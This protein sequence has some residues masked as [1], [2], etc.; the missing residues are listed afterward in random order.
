MRKSLL[1]SVP[2]SA[3]E[4]MFSGRHELKKVNG[5][6]FIDRDADVFKMVISYLRNG[7]RIHAIADE[8]LKERF[9]MELDYW[10][11]DEEQ[12]QKKLRAEK[13][14]DMQAIYDKEPT[15]VN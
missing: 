14:I 11:L 3:L 6:V 5:R 4:A 13:I 9:E 12:K 7:K 10:N 1:T 8:S 2:G 15:G